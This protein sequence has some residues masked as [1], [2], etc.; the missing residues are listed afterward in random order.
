M[1]Y[2]WGAIPGSPYYDEREDFECMDNL[3]LQIAYEEV[4]E[5][6]V[7][8]SD[9]LAE[10]ALAI[11]AEENAETQKY[12]NVCQTK[13]N[14]YQMKIDKAKTQLENKTRHLKQQLQQYFE[15][16]PHKATKTHET[17]KLPSGTLRLKYPTVEYRRD[18]K[19]LGEFL[20]SNNYNGYFEEVVK[21]KWAELKK[22]VKVCGKYVVDED[23][24]N[25]I[26]GVE[27]IEKP[28]EFEIEV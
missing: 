24:G 2:T 17:Y 14:E 6:F 7:I 8:N 28:A 3:A 23:S 10:W 12:I 13:I 18:E 9:N 27:V 25:I 19:V 22:V 15:T 1:D 4:Q 5:G 11:I 21:P 20:K 16:V 26:D